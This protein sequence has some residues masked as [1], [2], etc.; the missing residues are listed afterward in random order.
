MVTENECIT[1]A[2]LSASIGDWKTGELLS[3]VVADML[4]AGELLPVVIAD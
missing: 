3:A 2:P 1:T 4:L